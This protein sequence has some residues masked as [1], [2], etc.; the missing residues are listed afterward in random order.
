MVS[1][2]FRCSCPFHRTQAELDRHTGLMNKASSRNIDL[3]FVGRHLVENREL[4]K[5]SLVINTQHGL[6][7]C[8]SCEYAIIPSQLK[9]HLSKNHSAKLE[10]VDQT[11]ISHL[12]NVCGVNHTQLPDIP[13]ETS[14]IEGFPVCKGHPCPSCHVVGSNLESIKSHMRQH[15]KGVAYPR[16]NVLVP[17]QLI[18]KDKLLRVHA[19][20]EVPSKFTTDDILAQAA[21]MTQKACSEADLADLAA[22]DPREFC[23]WLRR[24]RWHELA[25]GKDLGKLVSLVAQP[26]PDEFPALSNGL[27]FLFRSASPFFVSTSELILQRLHSSKQG[28]E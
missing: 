11:G 22:T 24:V 9:A 26:K 15:H 5:H 6:L 28:E 18:R 25:L 8:L 3:V 10:A 17:F 23:P 27:L 7:I 13:S 20:K 12:L 4:A 2:G 16:A 21:L 19:Q 1:P 14:E